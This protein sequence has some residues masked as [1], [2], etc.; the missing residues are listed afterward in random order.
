MTHKLG[1]AKKGN[2]ITAFKTAQHFYKLGV[3]RK[4]KLNKA[5]IFNVS[6][7]QPQIVKTVLIEILRK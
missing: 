3:L 1:I 6:T 2:K 4:L 5:K 7:Y